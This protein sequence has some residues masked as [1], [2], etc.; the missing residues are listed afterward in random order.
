M[1]DENLKPLIP[2][3]CH[4]RPPGAFSRMLG[5]LW[6]TRSCPWASPGEMNP[7]RWPGSRRGEV[8]VRGY[9]SAEPDEIGV[10]PG[11]PDRTVK[12]STT[13]QLV[14]LHSYGARSPQ[15]Q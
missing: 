2:L 8:L 10:R 1:L 9:R 13:K 15:C 3:R 11:G 4:T 5:S 12:R 6:P 14:S 7:S